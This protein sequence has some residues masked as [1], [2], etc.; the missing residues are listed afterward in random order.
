MWDSQAYHFAEWLELLAIKN[1]PQPSS[2]A[3]LRSLLEGASD[4]MALLGD[5][6]ELDEKVEEIIQAVFEELKSRSEWAG[7]GYPFKLET[8]T[9][10][11]ATSFDQPSDAHLGYLL[12]L[13]ATFYRHDYYTRIAKPKNENDQ[14]PNS[15]KMEDYFQAC[16]TIAAAGLVS[17]N[18]ISFGFPREDGTSFYEKLSEISQ[19][20]AEGSPKTAW[21]PGASTNPK[22]A[23]VDIVAWRPF[24]DK[25]PGQ[26]YLLGQCASGDNWQDKNPHQDYSNFHEDYWTKRP[27]SPIILAMFVPFFRNQMS[28]S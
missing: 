25:Q 1:S 13:L 16:G 4:D 21:E 2:Q 11:L 12:S 18:S 6:S 5:P 8:G 17:G 23:G 3:D 20:L 10:T 22:D 27:H 14:F 28:T 24:A 15:G 26:F 7:P 9:I 19:H